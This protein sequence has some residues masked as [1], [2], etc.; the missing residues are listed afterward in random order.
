MEQDVPV[1]DALIREGRLPP[2]RRAALVDALARI[3]PDRAEWRRFFHAAG[4]GFGAASALSGGLYL[5]GWYWDELPVGL[6]LGLVLGP[7]CLAA[8]GAARVGP[9]TLVG[10]VLSAAVVVLVGTSLTVLSLAFPTDGEPWQLSAVWT[11]LALPVVVAAGGTPLWALGLWLANQ[12]A[13]LAS[14]GSE[15]ALLVGLVNPAVGEAFRGTWL[16]HVLRVFGVGV[17]TILACVRLFDH[18]WPGLVAIGALVAVGIAVQ[19]AF[20]V[21]RA[22][23]ATAATSLFSLVALAFAGLIRGLVDTRLLGEALGLLVVG[24]AGVAMV[25][26]GF[27]WLVG[28]PR[29]RNASGEREAA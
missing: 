26:L 15:M 14:D 9:R 24:A 18:G 23:V 11:A 5:V 3:G 20:V 16:Q 12:T 29:L 25:V 28:V 1:V 8:L 19:G 2:E 27:L 13:L 21:R 22:S 7:L 10:R 6:Q 4:L 17:L